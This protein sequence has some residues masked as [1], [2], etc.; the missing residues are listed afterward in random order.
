M[1]KAGGEGAISTLPVDAWR[2]AVR[3][4]RVRGWWYFAVLPLAA[5]VSDP[6]VDDRLALRLLTAI[7]IAALCLGYAFGINTIADRGMDRD[8]DK[9]SLAGLA[10]VPRE[11][12][13]LVGACAAGAIGIAVALSPI[14][15]LGAT[16]SL[17]AGTLYSTHLRLKR[18]PVVGTVVNV[19]IFAPLP[20][21]GVAGTPSLHM[22]F[23]TYCFCVLVAQNQILHE[24]ADAHEDATGG[25]RTTGVTVGAAGLPVI[26]V[27]LGPLAAVPIVRLAPDPLLLLAAAVALC[28][29][30][31]MVAVCDPQRAR[32]LRVIHRWLSLAAGCVLFAG[33]ARGGG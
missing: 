17:V 25:V 30:A 1:S 11:A 2:R 26:A 10:G 6:V 31:L 28:T 4:L 7:V 12:A 27:L 16:V 22:W 3:A 14:A 20:L 33:A 8:G 13:V 18:L 29:G 19:L 32:R 15:L 24:L 21:L 23:L 5:A 9:N